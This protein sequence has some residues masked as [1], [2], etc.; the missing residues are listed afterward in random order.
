[1]SE[2]LQH[3]SNPWDNV[4]ITTRWRYVLT[5]LKLL[6][7]LKNVTEEAVR[8][9]N[10]Q[11][12]EVKLSNPDAAAG[13]MPPDTLS[14][15][16]QKAVLASL[17]FV[18]C[19]GLVPCLHPGVGLPLSARSGFAQL[20]QSGEETHLSQTDKDTRL[21]YCTKVLLQCMKLPSLGGLILS[22]HLGDLLAA[23]CQI[24]YAPKQK[25][26]QETCKRPQTDSDMSV[27]ASESLKN[28]SPASVVDMVKQHGK[29]PHS[30]QTAETE[31]LVQHDLSQCEDKHHTVDTQ[32]YQN[33]LDRLLGRVYQPMLV[34][35]LLILQGG[36]GQ[37][38]KPAALKQAP[39]WLRKVCGKLLSD[40]L[41]KP[42][43][44]HNVLRG[45]LDIGNA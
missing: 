33:E 32:Y 31:Q 8:T 27:E 5:I 22:R 21:R 39:M 13:P 14:F 37:P 10:R 19:L 28:A 4:N 16:Q 2:L 18:V 6:V 34:R 42:K 7:V 45:M 11:R 40:R 23:L 17:Q 20:L 44:V 36:P 29:L 9:F 30:Q 26:T 3:V 38:G 24:C 25:V 12:S 41:A 1:M 35:E 15:K 43:G